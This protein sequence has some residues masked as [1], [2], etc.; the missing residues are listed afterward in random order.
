M[1]TYFDIAVLEKLNRNGI[2]EVLGIYWIDG[3]CCDVPEVL[4]LGN[5]SIVYEKLLSD[6]FRFSLNFTR[7]A[8]LEAFLVDDSFHFGVMLAGSS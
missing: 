6:L 8:S 1:N 2:I 7:E 3:E 5:L 4:S